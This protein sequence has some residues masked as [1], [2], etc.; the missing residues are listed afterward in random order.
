MAKQRFID[1]IKQDLL[2]TGLQARSRQARLWLAKKVKEV[3]LNS[4][5]RLGFVNL[6]AKSR[7]AS[8]RSK[9]SLGKMYFYFYDP[10]TKERLPYYDIMPLVIPIDYKPAVDSATGHDAGFLGLNLHYISPM[11]RM[12]LLDSLYTIAT[13]D[14]FD[15]NTRIKMRYKLLANSKNLFSDATPCLKWYLFKYFKSRALEISADEWEISCFLPFEAFQKKSKE[16][17]WKQSNKK[18]NK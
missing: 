16:Y 6:G 2:K 8:S 17:V 11:K 1:K 4:G 15:E 13:D 12:V 3:R 9:L 18:A 5:A 7:I 10:K 14:R